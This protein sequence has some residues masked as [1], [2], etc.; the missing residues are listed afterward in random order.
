M[1]SARKEK[2][3]KKRGRKKEKTK[4]N[5]LKKKKKKKDGVPQLQQ[6]VRRAQRWSLPVSVPADTTPSVC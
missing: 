5:E 2:R 3:K 6:A 1:V 4:Q